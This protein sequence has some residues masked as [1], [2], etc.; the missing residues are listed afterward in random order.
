MLRVSNVSAVTC[1]F[2]SLKVNQNI[3][4]ER[5]C[6]L[7]VLI[8]WII[9]EYVVSFGDF[10]SKSVC[11][12][13]NSRCENIYTDIFRMEQLNAI[14]RDPSYYATKQS[15][16]NAKNTVNVKRKTSKTAPSK[17]KVLHFQHHLT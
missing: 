15:T 11:V 8:V 14:L 16:N 17:R 12:A 2:F 9:E 13:K 7:S 6:V 10:A 4:G 1:L 5:S 3:Y